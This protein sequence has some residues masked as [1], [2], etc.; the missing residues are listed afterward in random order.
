MNTHIN[1]RTTQRPTTGG[2][3]RVS[4]IDSVTSRAPQPD[5]AGPRR[6]A[7]VAIAAAVVAVVGVGVGV[8][9]QDADGGPSPA[10][11]RS[12]AQIV[13]DEIDAALAATTLT[14]TGAAEL[15]RATVLA[16]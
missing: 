10:P 11:E 1:H 7:R 6:A 15:N 2:N 13:Q 3:T 5:D 14:A 12:S 4:S 16:D 8:V 9:V